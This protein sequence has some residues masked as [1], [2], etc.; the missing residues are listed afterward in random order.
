MRRICI[1]TDELYPF[2]AG[3][4]G[5]LLHNLV[6][7]AL[8]REPGIR[9]LFLFPS[10][11]DVQR[12]R[13]V[14]YFG[15][16]VEVDYATMRRGWDP[17]AEF[18]AE[19]PPQG[20]FTD[21]DW[22]AQS[23]DFLIALKRLSGKDFDVIEFPDY[24]GWAYCALQE[25]L[26]GR[27][28]QRSLIAVRIHSTDGIL[29]AFEGRPP[30]LQQLGRFELERKALLDAEKVIAHLPGVA[31]WNASYY[32]FP[33]S[34]H[35]KVTVEFPPVVEQEPS[36]IPAA[37]RR[38]D[39][40]FVTKQQPIK[41]PDVFIRGTS[42]FLRANPSFAGRA[43]L[44]C[45]AADDEYGRKLRSMVPADLRGRFHF[46]P[47][48][49]ERD[50]AIRGSIVVVPSAYESLNLA[51]YE[52]AAGGATLVLN[53][54]CIAFAAEAPWRDGVNCHKFDGTAEGLAAALGLAVA[55]RPHEAVRWEADV[56]Y[57]LS[58]HAAPAPEAGA[59]TPLV[60]VVVPNYNL[61]RWLPETLASVAASTYGEI[62]VV[63]VDDASTEAF[64]AAVLERLEAD[65]GPVRVV[66]NPVNRGL[67]ASRNIG[68]RAARGT[69]VLP[70]DA[71]DCIGPRF[72]E[73]AVAALEARPEF[74]VVV[75]TAGYFDSDAELAERRFADYAC[76]IGDAPSCGLV[77]NRMGCATSLMR[78]TLFDGL[79]Y[80][81]TLDSYE[82][83]S[84]YLRAVHQGRRFLVTNDVQF[85][86]RRRPGSMISGMN[87]D[88]H[89]AL[90]QRMYFSLAR[91][92]PVAV[93]PFALLAPLHKVN[94][95]N[96]QLAERV[97][98]LTPAAPKTVRHGLAD[99]VNATVKKVPLVHPMLKA[100]VAGLRG[101]SGAPVDA[102]RP[103]RYD[104]VDAMNV[105]LKRVPFLHPLL[106]ATG[107]KVAKADRK[108]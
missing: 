72:I 70:L 43:V 49:P 28:F 62:E 26:L 95:D 105:A 87:P 74:D 106:K 13:V 108:G 30:S 97:A 103:L 10:T 60:S 102:N 32:G 34:W 31:E 1:V 3:G 64:D 50:A 37:G 91:P 9:F 44:A 93:Q 42:T 96:Q 59:S 38:D 99:V 90:L 101:L 75:P 76:F 17:S 27:D 82:D 36:T 25:K 55:Q 4:I 35:D 16:G 29:Q 33:R 73:Q 14:A 56:P 45:H 68:I 78:R 2:T 20:A 39:I 12:E 77:A 65:P 83:W 21:S 67:A 61:G 19:Y 89:L 46:L 7:H 92:L 52:A 41:R 54:G 51:A 107:A 5:R 88:R 86:Y 6:R 40:V 8:Q 100:T 66:R 57:W 22:H 24:R 23:L 79:Q 48:G 63:V 53:R 80:D 81:E 98:A 71:D 18:G 85:Y 84:L 58:A 11:L 94:R 69:Y 15:D 47:S 104:V